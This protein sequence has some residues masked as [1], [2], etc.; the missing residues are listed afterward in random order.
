MGSRENVGCET[1][2]GNLISVQ[3]IVRVLLLDSQ[4]I[5]PIRN[6]FRPWDG[7]RNRGGGRDLVERKIRIERSGWSSQNT[8]TLFSS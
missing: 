2:K 1:E 3:K 6:V 5:G 8:E 7:M 4:Y